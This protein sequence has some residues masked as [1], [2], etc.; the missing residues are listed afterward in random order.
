MSTDHPKSPSRRD[1]EKKS[2]KDKETKSEKKHSLEKEEKEGTQ[3]KQKTFPN[4]TFNFNNAVD[5]PHEGKSFQ[6]ILQLPP[7]AL[8]G[9]APHS[10][11]TLHF[12]HIK[13][14]EDLGNW[15]YYRLAKAILTLSET[16]VEGKRPEGARSNINKGLDQEYEIKSLSEIVHA[17]PTA[18]SGLG[19]KSEEHL[20]A[21]HL[22]TVEALAKWKYCRRAEAIIELA[23]FENEDHHS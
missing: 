2:S 11:E 1:K 9:L 4:Y 23:K 13:T 18:L 5:K 15:K 21:L 22:K 16:E 7:S 17:P 12:F 20:N 6:E 3:K 19:P 10:D 8:Q 14:I